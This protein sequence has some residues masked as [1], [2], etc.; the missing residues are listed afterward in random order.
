MGLVGQR[1]MGGRKVQLRKIVAGNRGNWDS[2]AACKEAR[3]QRAREK[4]LKLNRSSEKTG[5]QKKG[6]KC[7]H[8][9]SCGNF[10]CKSKKPQASRPEL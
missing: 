8:S 7:N 2:G 1:S 4:L 5:V 6:S 10:V 3:Q 9:P